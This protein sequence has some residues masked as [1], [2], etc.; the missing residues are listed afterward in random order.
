MSAACLRHVV[1]ADFIEIGDQRQSERRNAQRRAPRMKLDTLFAATLVNHVAPGARCGR[2]AD[3]PR[4]PR[5]G[6]AFDLRA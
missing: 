3:T 2:Y 1:D 4:G 5:A 6:I